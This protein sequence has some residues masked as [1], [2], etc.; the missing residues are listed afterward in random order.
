VTRNQAA[1]LAG[2]GIG[3]YF[4]GMRSLV[5]GRRWPGPEP[6]TEER[7][8]E[9]EARQVEMRKAQ[10]R[11]LAQDLREQGLVLAEAPS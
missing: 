3:L 1:A 10:A 5:K 7:Q 6:W 9:W 2:A 11:V 8:A 4:A